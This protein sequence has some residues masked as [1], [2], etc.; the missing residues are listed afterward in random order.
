MSSRR[1]R[2]AASPDDLVF[3]ADGE[4]APLVLLQAEAVG[5]VAAHVRLGPPQRGH[6]VEQQG[7]RG[8]PA[9][10]V[11]RDGPVLQTDRLR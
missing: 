6:V 2:V 7:Q 4:L 9:V 1:V 3:Q 8:E 5:P 11:D 10:V